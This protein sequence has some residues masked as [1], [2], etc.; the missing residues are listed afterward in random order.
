MIVKA[1]LALGLACLPASAA[2]DDLRH[3]VVKIF[4]VVQ[5]P[6]YYQP[7]SMLNQESMT[8]SGVLVEGGR[9]LTNAHVVSD[10]SY[11]QVRKAGEARK[12]RARVEFVAHDCELAILRVDDPE[13]HRNVKPLPLGG[14]PKQRDRV[15]AYGFPTGGDELSVTEGTVSRIEVTRYSHSGYYL[16]TIQTDAA[17]NPGNSG[18]PVVKDGRIVGISFQSASGTD[19]IGYMVPSAVIRRFFSDVADGSYDRIPSIGISTQKLE[20]PALRDFYGVPKDKGG[21]LVNKVFPA[22]SAWG[23]L[24]PGDVIMAVDGHAIYSDG[25]YQLDVENRVDYTHLVAIRQTGESIT[26]DVLRGGKPLK[27][28]ISLRPYIDLV[29][30]PFYDKKPSYFIYGGLVFTPLSRNFVNLWDPRNQPTSFRYMQE[31]ER[32]TSKQEPVVMAFVLPHEVNEG[33]H[34]YRSMLVDSINGAPITRMADVIEAF[35]KPQGRFHVI[36]G[37]PVTEFS[38]RIILDA[39]AATKANREILQKN[40][41]VSDRSSDLREPPKAARRDPIEP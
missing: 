25:T 28:A 11:L 9:I 33:Y 17:I 12:Y 34:D 39:E 31:Y 27:Q 18:G 21:V 38:A 41:I 15:A 26:L 30:G 32:K 13:F 4:T 2:P 3:S 19:N 24:Q 8:G 6:N 35:Q 22:S 36:S 23:A 1:A 37:D 16:L 40:G 14:L 7:W 10:Q 29:D 20:S 5:R